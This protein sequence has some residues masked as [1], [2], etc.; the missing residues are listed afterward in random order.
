MT[1]NKKL[2]ILFKTSFSISAVTSGGWAIVASMKEKL[3]NEYKW[4][5]EEEILNL[6]S[7][8]QS[9]PGL[10]ATNTAV[11]VGYRIAG[12]AGSLVMVL[13]CIIPPI[14]IMSIVSVF[15]DFIKDNQ[16][17][18]Y[19]MKGMAAG[20]AALLVSVASGLIKNLV[21][22][23]SIVLYFIALLAFVLV[24]YLNVNILLIVFACALLGIINV[25]FLQKKVEEKK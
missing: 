20:V 11:L 25:F 6:F 21:K 9:T 17:I 13:G 1:K 19:I 24:R 12:I 18:K 4:I 5:S 7:I 16:I 10:I 22:E 3:V 14:V 15:Y 2:W 23:N 8:A